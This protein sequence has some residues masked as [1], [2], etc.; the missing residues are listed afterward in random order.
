MTATAWTA[1]VGFGWHE[2]VA[3]MPLSWLATTTSNDT[4]RLHGERQTKEAVLFPCKPRKA[5]S[6]QAP[7]QRNLVG[8]GAGSCQA[9]VEGASH[10]P[11]RGVQINNDVLC[12]LAV[13]IRNEGLRRG[14]GGA[15]DGRGSGWEA[16]GG[17][18]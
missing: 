14:H 5:S 18:R 4:S 2:R 1:A 13:H 3:M 10:A 12:F 9:D 11:G 7:C 6:F 15:H 17:W 8:V 16:A